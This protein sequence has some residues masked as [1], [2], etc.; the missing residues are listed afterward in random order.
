MK[1]ASQLLE[2][3]LKLDLHYSG[4]GKKKGWRERWKLNFSVKKLKKK[5]K[6]LF[7]H[8]GPKNVFPWLW[9]V[10]Y[11]PFQKRHAIAPHTHTYTKAFRSA[12]NCTCKSNFLL[13]I[14]YLIACIWSR[15]VSVLILLQCRHL[16]L[17]MKLKLCILSYISSY[18]SVVSYISIDCTWKSKRF[19]FFLISPV[20]KHLI[21]IFAY[22]RNKKGTQLKK[23]KLTCKHYFFQNKPV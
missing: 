20:C 10:I 16:S 15:Y 22:T 9:N 3:I 6:T 23:K 18:I 19:F 21:C 4:S 5:K 17:I 2:Y 12:I 13:H 7:G 14:Y 8:F 1:F 11:R